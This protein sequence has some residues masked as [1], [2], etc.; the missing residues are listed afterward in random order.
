MKTVA[1]GRCSRCT[2]LAGPDRIE[3]VLVGGVCV[4]CWGERSRGVPDIPNEQEED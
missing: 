1:Y 4:S 3:K 2:I